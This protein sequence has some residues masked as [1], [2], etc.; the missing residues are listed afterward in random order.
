MKD[1]LLKGLLEALPKWHK[2]KGQYKEFGKYTECNHKKNDA[3]GSDCQACDTAWLIMR[4]KVLEDAL[5]EVRQAIKDYVGKLEIDVDEGK[6]KE[7]IESA[8]I[9]FCR[10]KC[11][12]RLKTAS[13]CTRGYECGYIDNAFRIH[14]L[15]SSGGI[16]RVKGEK[17]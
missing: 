2:T 15:A 6:A 8:E 4:C 7:I 3:I 14:A 5:S 10:S 1:Q 13:N 17:K 9:D 11:P 16:I 12:D